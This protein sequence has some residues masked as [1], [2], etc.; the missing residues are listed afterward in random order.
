MTV[1]LFQN[2]SFLKFNVELLRKFFSDASGSKTHT[3]T[4]KKLNKQTN[5]QKQRENKV[6]EIQK[7]K[8]QCN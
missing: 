2:L 8:Y 6:Q 7:D 4:H 1:S 5:I 3:H